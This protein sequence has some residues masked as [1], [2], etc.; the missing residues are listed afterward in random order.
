MGKSR[1]FETSETTTGCSTLEKTLDGQI[2]MF[3]EFIGRKN[4]TQI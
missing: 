1:V 3:G 4:V 2:P